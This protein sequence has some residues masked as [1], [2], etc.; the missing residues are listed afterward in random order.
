MLSQYAIGD[1]AEGKAIFAAS[2][3]S[4]CHAIDQRGGSVGPDLTEIGIRRTTKSLRLALVNPDAEI[5]EEYLTVVIETKMEERVEGIVLNE[6]DLSIQLRDA[7][8]NP[9]SFLKNTLKELRREERSL[10]PSYA[11]KLRPEQLESLVSYLRT[12]RGHPASPKPRTRQ[13]SDATE[14]NAWLTRPERDGDERPDTLLKA[15]EIRPGATVVDLGAGAGYFTWRLA[16]RV[17]PRGKVVAVDIQQRMLDLTAAETRK[18]HLKNIEFQRELKLSDASVD[19]VLIANAY[20]EFSEP[21]AIL[22][23]VRRCLKPG[24]KLVVVEYSKEGPQLPISQLH[25]MG[26]EDLRSEIEAAGF[27]LDLVLDFL[28]L[29]HGLIFVKRR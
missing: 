7:L 12:L 9:R 25:T 18:R 24:G 28:P 11:A 17:G 14:S 1:A 2:G 22:A 3:C 8:G 13:P 19:L 27:E 16:E 10:M 26:F 20:H 23:I 5:Y 15:L 4:N 21:E 29:Q 6:D